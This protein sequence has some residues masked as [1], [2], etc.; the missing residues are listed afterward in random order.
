LIIEGWSTTIPNYNPLDIIQNIKRQMVNE[1]LVSMTPWWRGFRGALVPGSEGRWTAGGV[2]RKID[3]T[4]VEITELPIRKWTQD[5]KKLLEQMI[6]EKNGSGVKVSLIKY[7]T[8]RVLKN[9]TGLQRV[10]RQHAHPF[11]NHN[12]AGRVGESRSTRF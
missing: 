2:A 3:E 5:F 6:E 4:T 11:Y 1:P 7:S 8:I 12:V 9:K 10:S